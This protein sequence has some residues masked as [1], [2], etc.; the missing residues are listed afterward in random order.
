MYKYH[1]TPRAFT[2]LLPTDFPFLNSKAAHFPERSVNILP[3]QDNGNLHCHR[4][5]INIQYPLC[6]FCKPCVITTQGKPRHLHTWN[7]LTKFLILTAKYI[8]YDKIASVISS[9]V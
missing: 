2:L 6:L 9:A 3:M 4:R 1:I 7:T 8:L 5:D